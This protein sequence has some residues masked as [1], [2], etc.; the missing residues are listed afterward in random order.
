MN[1][2]NLTN[3][4]IK[5]FKIKIPRIEKKISFNERKHELVK[6]INLINAFCKHLPDPVKIRVFKFYLAQDAKE[7]LRELLQRKKYNSFKN[8]Y[9][10]FLNVFDTKSFKIMYNNELIDLDLN[11][12]DG[13]LGNY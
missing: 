5:G 8:F 6:I 11:P 3:L 13:T 10:E 4:S 9:E 7:L 12:K 1:Y 2:L